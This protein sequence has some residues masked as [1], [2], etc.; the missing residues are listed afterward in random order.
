MAEL[1]CVRPLPTI[2][3]NTADVIFQAVD[4]HAEDSDNFDTDLDNADES[5][6]TR[7]VITAFGVT[8]DGNSITVDIHGFRPC[9]YV[10]IPDGWSRTTVDRVMKEVKKRVR[11]EIALKSY[12]IVRRK[13]MAGFNNNKEFKFIE[14]LFYTRKAVS[15]FVRNIETPMKIFGVDGSVSLKTWES[16]IDP[17][18]RFMHTQDLSPAGWM[19]LPAKKY[20][21]SDIN[22]SLCQISLT[23]VAEEVYPYEHEGVASLITAS[24]DIEADSSHGDFPVAQK[25]YRKLAWDLSNYYYLMK[26]AREHGSASSVQD[27]IQLAFE[28]EENDIG[29]SRVFA[30]RNPTLVQIETAAKAI[31]K[32]SLLSS[33]TMLKSLKADKAGSENVSILQRGETFN[34][35]IERYMSRLTVVLDNSLPKVQGDRVIQIGT[36]FT[37]YGDPSFS[38]RHVIALDEC[39]GIDDTI[40]E[41]CYTEKDVLLAWTRLMQK[42]DP[43][44]II[45][46]NLLYKQIIGVSQS[47]P[48]SD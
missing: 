33:L 11:S 37:K 39:E 24:F 30:I 9:F 29:I 2:T 38:I 35:G 3:D 31:E 44:V 43:D 6:D 22:R 25:T 41:W 12:R 4:W 18:L 1:D 42:V 47:Q 15:D 45:G 48:V 7:Y 46:E 10:E 32:E 28:E 26:K 27:L 8:A 19:R 13:K 16:N 23:T 34:A 21:I 14:L 17:L 40:V 5:L 36:T 20:E